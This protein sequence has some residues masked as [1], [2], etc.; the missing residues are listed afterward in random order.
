[1]RI[2]Y[3]KEALYF[4]FHYYVFNF[5]LSQVFSTAGPFDQHKLLDSLGKEK[6]NHCQLKIHFFCLKCDSFFLFLIEFS[7]LKLKKLSACFF[8]TFFLGLG[9]M[10][11]PMNTALFLTWQGA[12]RR[13]QSNSL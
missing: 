3:K 4:M 9:F 1:M 13:S 7:N 5:C 11:S 2:S 8:F 12:Q 10:I 6:E